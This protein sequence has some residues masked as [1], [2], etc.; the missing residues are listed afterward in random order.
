MT[1]EKRATRIIRCPACQRYYRLASMAAPPSGARLRCTKCGEVFLF[2]AL[3][4]AEMPPAAAALG[5]VL[6]AT[7]GVEFQALISEVLRAVGYELKLARKGDV[8]WRAI[9]EW[10]PQV[11]LLDVA[12]PV[13]PAFEL[14]ERVRATPERRG[15]GLILIASVFQPTRYKRA[16]TSLYGADDYI[17]K[18]HIKDR[19][20]EKVGRLMGT[21]ASPV[22]PPSLVSSVP[23][24][25]PPQKLCIDGEEQARL[26]HEEIYGP[27]KTAA[28]RGSRDHE[29]HPYQGIDRLRQSLKRYARII[30]AD[31]ALY[32]QELVEQG[33]RDGSFRRVLKKELEEGHRLYL[34]RVPSSA[35]EPDYYQEA[36]ENFI[37]NH[38]GEHPGVPRGRGGHVR[39]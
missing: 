22:A 7:D 18:H 25:H 17:E 3:H 12:L 32:N 27:G 31:I 20:P 35:R 16:P 28:P 23:H 36:V 29:S 11:A 34:T 21:A 6:V 26:I 13:L 8:A 1:E 9:L 30:V 33:I 37:D 10:Q 14:C 39:P 19:L 15:M 24:L 4:P 2:S 5:R 38:K